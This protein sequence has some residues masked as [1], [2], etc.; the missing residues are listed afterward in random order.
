MQ[1]LSIR[2]LSHCHI[3]IFRI[4]LISMNL[5]WT[6]IKTMLSPPFF[7]F[8]R[9]A[10]R[11]R[12]PFPSSCFTGVGGRDREPSVR[13]SE[14]T[15][16]SGHW[17]QTV[18]LQIR[19]SCLLCVWSWA[20]KLLFLSFSFFILKMKTLLNWKL[21]WRLSSRKHAIQQLDK[22]ISHHGTYY[23]Y[24]GQLFIRYLARKKCIRLILFFIRF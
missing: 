20:I 3:K 14:C 23:S 13:S 5:P 24:I 12:F 6:K 22:R 8:L 15:G 19:I 2:I 7:S 4:D 9:N 16:K 11:S 10:D 18:F 17:N 21:L 1:F